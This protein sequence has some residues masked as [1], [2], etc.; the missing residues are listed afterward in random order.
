MKLKSSLILCF[1]YFAAPVTFS[2]AINSSEAVKI[3]GIKQWVKFQGVDDQAP[4]LLFLHGGPGN[5]VMSYADRFTKELQQHFVIVLWDQ[6]ESGETARLNSSG[7]PISIDLME[8]DA[9]ELINYLRI[10][11]SCDKIYLAGHSWGGFLGLTVAAN[12]PELLNAYIA[13]SPM[14]HQVE[15]ERISLRWMLDKA[16]EVSNKQ[17]LEELALV[18]IPF[19]NPDQLYY[20]RKWITRFQGGKVP[21]KSFVEAWGNKWLNLFNAA[22]QINFITSV[23]AIECPLYFF[24]GSMDYQTCFS[25]AES[26]YQQ[27]VCKEK[28]LT[29]FINSAHNPH[30]TESAKFQETIIDIKNQ[31]LKS[32]L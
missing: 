11:F 31:K 3:G 21:S 12:H 7:Q 20:H 25:L 10:R 19:Q 26:Y 1:I 23:P 17:A 14:I 8:A 6:R 27:V 13:I 15:S 28:K 4:V 5:S 32:E 22:S 16:K 24:L 18:N 9:V 2:A 29:W 30:L